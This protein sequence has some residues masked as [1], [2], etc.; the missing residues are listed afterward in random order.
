MKKRLIT[1]LG[2]GQY[3]T[4]LYEGPEGGNLK[5]AYVAH[6]IARLWKVDEVVA[7]ATDKAWETHGRGLEHALGNQ[8]PLK[9]NKI[10]DGKTQEE[11]WRQL[12]VLLQALS[13]GKDTELLLDITHGFRSQPFFAAGALGLLRMAGVLDGVQVH[14]LYGR[15]L[16]EEPDRS[17]IWDL[18]PMMEL[19]DWAHGAAVFTTTGQGD[20]LV[21]V[22]R[23]AD[24]TLRRQLATAG[25]RDFPQTRPL[26]TTIEDFTEDLATVRVASLISGYAQDDNAKSRARG[27]AERLLD[28]LDRY[29]DQA[30]SALPALAVVLKQVDA[31]AQGLSAERLASPEGDQAMACLARRYLKFKRYPEAAI[32]LREALVSRH[33]PGPEAVEVNCKKFDPTAREA[34]ERRWSEIDRDAQRDVA[35]VRNDIEHGGFRNQP[36]SASALTKNLSKLVERHLPES[37]ERPQGRTWFVTRH[38]GAVEWAERQGLQIDCQTEHLK[39]EDIRDGD[40]VIG[41]LPAHLAAEA[42]ARGA[43]YLHLSLDLPPELRGREL[44]ADDL[45]RCG[46]RLEPLRVLRGC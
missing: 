40:T 38:P 41:T 15:Y 28:A 14:V 43:R 17:P 23:R 19:L 42:C 36:Q 45:E 46:A 11:L 21:E 26:I 5:T 12:D 6:A 4:T 27:S 37:E 2:T 1:F 35:K 18:T 10:P 29:R 20:R 39:T 31:V 30:A 25:R 8:L 34:A 44:S 33:A 9:V 22:A 24:N 7:L 13:V 3:K 32:V 16:P